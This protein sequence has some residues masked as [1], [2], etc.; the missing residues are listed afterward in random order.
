[1]Q[2]Y[3]ELIGHMICSVDIGRLEILLETSLLSSYLAISRVGKPEQ[4]FY[5][6]GYLKSH[7]KRKLVFDLAH[8]AINKNRFRQCE[9]MECYRDSE[10]VIPGNV[11]VARGNFMYMHCFVDVNHASDIDTR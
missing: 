10:E 1:M 6:F 3:Q 7:P 8:P 4:A 11:L 2:Q 9:C 5:I